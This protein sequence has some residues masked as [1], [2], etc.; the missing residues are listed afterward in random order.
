MEHSVRSPSGRIIIIND[1]WQGKN[2][3]VERRRIQNRLNQRAARERWR[4]NQRTK[5]S[6][7]VHGVGICSERIP[8]NTDV[9]LDSGIHEV[10]NPDHMWLQS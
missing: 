7:I 3:P 4:V 8:A 5:L 6:R 1:N 2:D 9:S 10:K